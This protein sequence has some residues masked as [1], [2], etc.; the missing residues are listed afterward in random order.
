MLEAFDPQTARACVRVTG[1]VESLP[2]RDQSFDALVCLEAIVHFDCP[3]RVIA[4]FRRVLKPG[5]R[6]L[7]SYDN[8]WGL[9]RVVKNVF[10]RIISIV[11]RD[12]QAERERRRAIY[13]PRSNGEM[14]RLLEHNGFW[15]QQRTFIGVIMPFALGQRILFGPK[16][17][18]AARSFLEP[19]DR[20]PGVRRLATYAY[21]LARV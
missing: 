4:E 20:F 1:D 21:I 14:R 2:F 13:T 5:G 8:R 9:L 15:I 7:I 3:E 6:L 17:Y 16:A 10:N 12:F 11:S 18:E 19:L